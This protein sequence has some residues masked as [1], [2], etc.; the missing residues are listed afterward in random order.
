VTVSGTV[1]NDLGRD[2]LRHPLL[3]R[4][5][6]GGSLPLPAFDAGVSKWLDLE[7]GVQ[8]Q[9]RLPSAGAAQLATGDYWLIPARTAVGDVLWPGTR[10]NPSFM[11]TQGRNCFYAPLGIVTTDAAGN[12]AIA[13]DLRRVIK[14]AWA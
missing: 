9:L 11:P 4:W 8:I 5:D 14:Q 13:T 2:P 10:S 3:R 1:P 6:S 7:D 12:I